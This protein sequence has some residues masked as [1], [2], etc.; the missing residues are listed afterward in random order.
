[1]IDID[2]DISTAIKCRN[3]ELVV[4]RTQD[5]TPYLEENVREFNEAPTWRP[6]SGKERLRKVAEIPNIVIEQWLKEGIN[7]FS[8]DPAQQR[9]FRAKLDDYTNQ[10]LRTYPG[11]LG[12]RRAWV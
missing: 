8:P 5:T 6:Y 10:K 2:T 4:R 12:M 9:A 7:I 3:G 11:R 1:M